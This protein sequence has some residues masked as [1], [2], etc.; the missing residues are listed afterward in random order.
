M[1]G[2]SKPSYILV[3]KALVP[4]LLAALASVA[5]QP[6]KPSLYIWD[7]DQ[8]QSGVADT[9]PVEYIIQNG[10]ADFEPPKA[11]PGTAAN[12]LA[13][14]CFSSGTSGLVKGVRL[15]HGNVVSNL[16]QQ[17]Q[18]LR[19][20]FNPCTVLALVVPYFHILGLAGFCCQYVCQVRARISSI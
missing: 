16:F 8:G 2:L 17:S 1:L 6:G 7:A 15:S 13:F 20:M 10:S 9:L 3:E 11:P 19:G 5:T 4:K 14:I 18:A 12:N